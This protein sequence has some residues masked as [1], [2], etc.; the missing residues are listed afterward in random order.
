MLFNPKPLLLLL[1]LC[2]SAWSAKAQFIDNVK[3]GLGGSFLGTGDITVGK[4]EGEVTHNW[5][6]FFS[7]STVL[8]VGYASGN[9][10]SSFTT[11]QTLLTQLDEN[12]FF[13]PFGNDNVYNFK[14]GTG[15]SLV[16]IREH[17]ETEFTSEPNSTE[18]RVSLGGAM[19]IEQEI[20]IQQQ[21][22]VGLKAMIQ[23]YLNGD[24]VNS[25]LL[26]IGVPL[27]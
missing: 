1:I 3:L 6:R 10:Y 12:I 2:G 23:P 17:H 13:S 26:K 8:G 20:L 9:S 19:I 25:L 4:V 22:I 15:V 24:I 11:R 16:Y 7:G 14:I 21:L 18:H 5:N 27:R